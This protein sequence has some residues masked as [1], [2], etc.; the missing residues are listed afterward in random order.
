MAVEEDA[1]GT[2]AGRKIV[3]ALIS[4]VEQQGLPAEVW[5]NGRAH[6]TGFYQR[7]GFQQLGDVFE[8]PGTGPH[9]VMVK[10]LAPQ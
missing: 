2:G 5:C 8:I 3:E 6:V 1:R 9:V 7:L 10:T 4:Y